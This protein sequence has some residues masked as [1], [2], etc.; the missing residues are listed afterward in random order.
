MA[1]VGSVPVMLAMPWFMVPP[2]WWAQGRAPGV[3]LPGV[4][5]AGRGQMSIDRPI[6]SL[7][8]PAPQKD[9]STEPGRSPGPKIDRGQASLG[10]PQRADASADA[11]PSFWRP[12]LDRRPCGS[13]PLVQAESQRRRTEQVAMPLCS[14]T[15]RSA[16]VPPRGALSREREVMIAMISVMPPIET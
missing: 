15:A 10:A 9:A 4:T 11:I 5:L 3:A 14:A 8:G 7:G 6:R 12:H 13:R 1:T 2:G 16:P